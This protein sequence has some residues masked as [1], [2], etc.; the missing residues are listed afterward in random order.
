MQASTTTTRVASGRDLT[1]RTD[2]EAHPDTGHQR[3]EGRGA[4]RDEVLGTGMGNANSFHPDLPATQDPE[5]DD[6]N[7]DEAWP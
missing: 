1:L 2:E 6:V 3:G 5:A 4:T 7:E